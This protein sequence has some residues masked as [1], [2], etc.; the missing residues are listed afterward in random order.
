MRRGIS[1][2]PEIALHAYD[3]PIRPFGLISMSTH[4]QWV[5]H[6]KRRGLVGLGKKRLEATKDGP[7]GTAGGVREDPRMH[8]AVAEACPAAPGR[9]LY[10][11]A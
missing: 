2:A 11:Q 8:S 5:K 7:L 4:S 3:L 6:D 1:T 9:Q 10:G